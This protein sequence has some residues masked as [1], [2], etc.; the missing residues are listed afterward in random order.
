MPNLE[1]FRKGLRDLG[2]VEGRDFAIEARFAEGKPER[3][4]ELAA[5]LVRNRVDIILAGSTPG[6]LAAKRA[7]STIPVVMVT[8]G[9][10]VEG[11][12]VTSLAH[13]GGNVTGVTALGDVLSV[14][15]YQE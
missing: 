12:L 8:T 1:A 4:P 7:T 14:K 10:P 6:A 15:R 9:D 11:G 5:Q 3:L 2:W 13:P